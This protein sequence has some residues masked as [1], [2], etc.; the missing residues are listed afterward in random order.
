MRDNGKKA[1]N[2]GKESTSYQIILS[3]VV[4]GKM[5]SELNGMMRIH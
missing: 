2:T 5:E 4:N 1:N 3:D